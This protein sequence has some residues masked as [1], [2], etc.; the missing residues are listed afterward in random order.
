MT[1]DDLLHRPHRRFNPLTREWVVVSPQRMERPWQ[2]LV[3]KPPQPAAVAYDPECYL[4][5]GNARAAGIRNPDYKS[6][7]VFDNDFAAL[8]PTTS[9]EQIEVDGLLIAHGERGICR[10]ASFSE[11]HDLTLALMPERDIRRVVDIWVQQYKELSSVPWVEHVQI[12]ENRGAIMGASNPHPHCQIWGNASLPNQAERELVSQAEYHEKHNSCL[13]C[14]Y[15]D[16]ELKQELR[17]VS[18]NQHFVV[19]VPFWAMWPF[20]VMVL[21][22]RHVGAMDALSETELNS[23]AEI[24]R[25]LCVRYDNLFEVPFPY[26]MGF[27]Q[28][29]TDNSAHPEW[30]FHAH[31]YPPLLR[32]ATVPKFMVGFEMLGSP[33]R[34][35]TPEVAAERL[36]VLS[37]VHYQ[38]KA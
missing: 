19:L 5:P 17:V 18:R 30:H 14:D 1:L 25:R 29:P 23:L 22:A 32:S 16:L 33:Q 13:L 7:F 24:L 26:T 12:F 27:H 8:L 38:N 3:E 11:R 28:K 10:V 2:G 15:L 9:P 6:T 36:R 37:E 34:D 21:S 4:C 31:Y 35:L 20:E